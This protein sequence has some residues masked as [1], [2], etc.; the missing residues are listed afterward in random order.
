MDIYDFELL[1]INILDEEFDLDPAILSATSNLRKDCGLDDVE[2][3]EFLQKCEQ[4]FRISIPPME[5]ADMQT[6][7]DVAAF[8][9][10]HQTE[11]D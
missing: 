5:E 1:V 4:S 6:V 11:S 2:V 8:I 9:Q 3:L 7:G 10:R